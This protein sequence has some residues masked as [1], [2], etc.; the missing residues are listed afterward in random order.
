[1]SKPLGLLLQLPAIS[2]ISP[3]QLSRDL[4]SLPSKCLRRSDSQ[5]GHYSFSDTATTTTVPPADFSLKH[6]PEFQPPYPHGRVPFYAQSDSGLYGGQRVCFGNHVARDKK[7]IFKK[8]RRTWRPNV[9]EQ[10]L[11]SEALQRSVKL[12]VT[13]RV[14]RTIDKLGGIDEYLLGEK[15]LRIRELGM[16][17]WK[18][19]WELMQSPAVQK[20]FT[21][22]REAFGL[23]QEW[24]KH[25]KI[26]AEGCFM[27][28]DEEANQLAHPKKKPKAVPPWVRRMQLEAIGK[29]KP[30]PWQPSICLGRRF[31]GVKMSC[32]AP[33]AC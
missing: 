25:R 21:K 1:M 11:W 7:R 17:G 26:W 9:Q 3:S 2:Y 10:S 15:S 27:A 13:A 28:L 32:M 24:A 29:D 5:S 4:A 30:V 12:R 6:K 22:Q 16:T 23:P 33:E 18:W 20:R 14:L 8:E 31:L 19:R